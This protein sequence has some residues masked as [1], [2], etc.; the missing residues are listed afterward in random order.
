MRV[1]NKFFYFLFLEDNCGVCRNDF[2]NCFQIF[3]FFS[4]ILNIIFYGILVIK[5]YYVKFLLFF[6]KR[7]EINNRNKLEIICN[8][9]KLKDFVDDL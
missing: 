5:N 9:V 1:I 3:L 7:I 8:I 6:I 2:N 4:S